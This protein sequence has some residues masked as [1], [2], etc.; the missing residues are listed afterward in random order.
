MSEQFNPALNEEI[1]EQSSG[2]LLSVEPLE[3]TNQPAMRLADDSD[4]DTTDASDDASDA[5]GTDAADADG[6]DTGVD[7]D[8]TKPLGI[9][10]SDT[11][12]AGDSDGSDGSDSDGT[13]SS[14][15]SDGKDS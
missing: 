1:Q 14:R 4:T 15:D 9:G 3:G 12:D 6:T 8:G 10:D 11:V 5:D 13:D 7:A 2:L